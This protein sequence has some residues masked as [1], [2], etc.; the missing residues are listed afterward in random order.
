MMRSRCSVMKVSAMPITP[1]PL[2]RDRAAN[3]ASMSAV[4]PQGAET[5][6]AAFRDSPILAQLIEARTARELRLNNGITV[7]VRAADFR[8]LRG[9]TF[10]GCIADEVAF[11]MNEESSNPDTEILNA[12]RPGLA[13]TSGPLFLIS[14][15]YA[16]KGELWRTYR[17][18][19]SASGD[20]AILVAQ[21]SSR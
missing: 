2:S 19:Y 16:R 10:I 7:E 1:P 20:S 4:L 18:H 6:E 12:I 17:K 14:S 3:A 13:T 8:R 11:W 21:G 9:L 15:P 5:T